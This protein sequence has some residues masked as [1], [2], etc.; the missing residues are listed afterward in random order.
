MVEDGQTV[1]L[2][3]FRQ[4]RDEFRPAGVNE[5]RAAK[6]SASLL[7]SKKNAPTISGG[8]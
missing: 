4:R 3:R 1:S 7:A 6:M 2:P 8:D 5:A